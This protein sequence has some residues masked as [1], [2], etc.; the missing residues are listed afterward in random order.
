MTDPKLTRLFGNPPKSSSKDRESSKAHTNEFDLTWAPVSLNP[1]PFLDITG[2]QEELNHWAI[3][4]HAKNF[5]H[6]SCVSLFHM[7]QKICCKTDFKGLEPGQCTCISRTWSNERTYCCWLH[8][9]SCASSIHHGLLKE[10]LC[11]TQLAG[12]AIVLTTNYPHAHECSLK[13]Q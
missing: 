7:L 3:I 2:S 6:F 8:C 9:S 12:Q 11:K 1:E 5:S 10:G 4:T 13:T